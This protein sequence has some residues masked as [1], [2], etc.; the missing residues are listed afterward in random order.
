[1]KEN[2]GTVTQYNQKTRLVNEI[3]PNFTSTNF[4]L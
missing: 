2:C 3:L 4:I 1:M